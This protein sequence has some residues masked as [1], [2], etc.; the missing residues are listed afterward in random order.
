MGV[1]VAAG[2]VSSLIFCLFG[3]FRFSHSPPFCK[4]KNM[5]L[6]ARKTPS[7]KLLTEMVYPLAVFQDFVLTVDLPIISAV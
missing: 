3:S 5:G 4:G 2:A 1:E 7:L 6:I